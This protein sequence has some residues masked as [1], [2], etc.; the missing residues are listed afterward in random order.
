MTM[1]RTVAPAL[2]LGGAVRAVS[3][4][5]LGAWFAALASALAIAVGVSSDAAAANAPSC[6]PRHAHVLGRHG[7]SRLFFLVTGAGDE[8]GTPITIFGCLRGHRRTVR[9]QRFDAETDV[10][11]RHVR[12]AG[13]YAAFAETVTDL[14]CS[15]YD[16]ANPAC[17]SHQIA[18]FDLRTGRRRARSSTVATALVLVRRGWIAWTQPAAT[19]G[20]TAL[21]AIDSLGPRPLDDGPIA[22]ASV[23][24]HG[25][26][27]SWLHGTELRRAWLQ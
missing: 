2:D 15:K 5:P 12:F 10:E 27:V 11:V 21:R 13:P 26:V 4:S 3:G 9:L 18:S 24:S 16:P 8:Y 20:G 23:R 17:S 6:S 7:G 14:P 19:T 25:N 1:R 22:P